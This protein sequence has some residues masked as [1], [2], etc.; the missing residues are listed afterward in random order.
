M[1]E[2]LMQYGEINAGDVTLTVAADAHTMCGCKMARFE[3]NR[4]TNAMSIKAQL[5]ARLMTADLMQLAVKSLLELNYRY[6]FIM[7]SQKVV[8]SALANDIIN[9]E[10]ASEILEE[11]EQRLQSLISSEPAKKISTKKSENK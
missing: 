2:L 10:R 6:D 7:F 1:F 11:K 9:Q 3:W 5:P 8:S 4:D